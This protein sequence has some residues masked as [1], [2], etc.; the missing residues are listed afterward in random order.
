[1]ISSYTID[2][3]FIEIDKGN[4]LKEILNKGLFTEVL[5][6]DKDSTFTNIFKNIV[7]RD[8][9]YKKIERFFLKNTNV[10]HRN[11]LNQIVTVDCKYGSSFADFIDQIIKN[12]IHLDYLLTSSKTHDYL[13]NTLGSEKLRNIIII[14][15]KNY[16][17]TYLYESIYKNRNTKIN[18]KLLESDFKKLF[19]YSDCI[20]IYLAQFGK[21]IEVGDNNGN[22]TQKHSSFN[23]LKNILKLENAYKDK[24]S[25][26][27]N[28]KLLLENYIKDQSCSWKIND[29]DDFIY[30]NLTMNGGD[31]FLKSIMTLKYFFMILQ[32]ELIENKVLFKTEKKVTI[33]VFKSHSKA[34]FYL[35]EIVKSII[36]I[37]KLDKLNIKIEVM[38]LSR[39]KKNTLKTRQSHLR[40]ILT[41][42][43]AIDLNAISIYVKKKQNKKDYDT[44]DQY[45]L[46]M[47]YELDKTDFRIIRDHEMLFETD[48]I[49]DSELDDFLKDRRH[50]IGER[51]SSYSNS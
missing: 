31:E 46:N 7:K 20:E 30:N 4:V 49:S 41:R 15:E 5:I 14:N 19:K 39:D 21:Q 9:K 1:M 24:L 25:H 38:F 8:P 28:I 27:E 44:S 45:V 35:N 43:R 51:N 23:P 2:P 11:F 33:F 10:G 47:E 6:E 13:L 48:N 29:D 26:T 17:Q 50:F 40:K 34:N 18:L 36:N 37:C 16:N 42:Q 22:S 3:E 32:N 12:K